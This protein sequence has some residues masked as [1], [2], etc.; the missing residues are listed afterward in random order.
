MDAGASGC[1]IEQSAADAVGLD[2][3]GELFVSSVTGQFGSRFRRA[4]TLTLGPLTVENPLFME[5]ALTGLV[6][7]APDNVIGIIGYDVFRRAIVE[8]PTYLKSTINYSFPQSTPDS[9]DSD[10]V[11]SPQA[12]AC[13]TAVHD[14]SGPS[15]SSNSSSTNSGVRTGD[16]RPGDSSTSPGVASPAS[17]SDSRTGSE[18]SSSSSS[19]PGKGMDGGRYNYHIRLHDPSQERHSE[20][21][22]YNWQR[23]SMIANLPHLEVRFK[24]GNGKVH[25][26]IMML[27]S[28]AGGADLM[29]HGRAVKSLNLGSNRGDTVKYVRG[30]GGSSMQNV[31]AWS[32]NFAWAEVASVRFDLVKCLFVPNIL[33]VSVYSTGIVCADLMTRTP[34][35]LDYAR[36][37]IGFLK[38]T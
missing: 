31:K 4:K 28:G 9:K 29:F 36:K 7:D 21:S 5:M 12:I 13:A 30:V 24:A 23:M 20:G 34:V 27:D 15:S 32:G 17:S 2:S 1:V 11:L 8:I 10:A 37:R 22:D 35:V 26:V 16:G 33:D 14:S 18:P 38:E 6:K 25:D 3:F 19:R